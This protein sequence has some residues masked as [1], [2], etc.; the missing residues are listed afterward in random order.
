MKPSAMSETRRLWSCKNK[1]MSFS[2]L[3]FG[4][5]HC[6]DLGF[7]VHLIISSLAATEIRSIP[8]ATMMLCQHMQPATDSDPAEC[9]PVDVYDWWDDIRG[10]CTLLCQRRL[11]KYIKHIS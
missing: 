5:N 9:G 8:A 3:P 7:F 1:H 2:I 10:E 6:N 11:R 4:L